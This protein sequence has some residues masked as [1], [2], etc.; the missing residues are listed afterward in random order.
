[1]LGVFVCKLLTLHGT[2]VRAR[3]GKTMK[4]K[5]VT[6]NVVKVQNTVYAFA[7]N[8]NLLVAIDI[9][10]EKISV[11][12]SI[13]NEDFLTQFLVGGIVFAQGKLY[14]IPHHAKEMWIVDTVSVNWS[15]YTLDAIT[16]I[17]NGKFNAAFLYHDCIYMVGFRYPGILVHD[18]INNTDTEYRIFTETDDI[19]SNDGYIRKNCCLR[20]EVLYAPCMNKNEI[21]YFNM[22]DKKW[23][24]FNV[25]ESKE[26]FSGIAFYNGH[27]V[28]P[29]RFGRNTIICDGDGQ[30]I[31]SFET[32]NIEDV[33]LGAY[34]FEEKVIVPGKMPTKSLIIDD[35]KV[36]LSDKTYLAVGNADNMVYTQNKEFVL[37]IYE[38]EKL[39]F[40]THTIVDV[41]RDLLQSVNIKDRILTEN[42]N[43]ID[44]GLFIELIE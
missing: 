12:G 10:T 44:L 17:G 28:L 24:L 34:L 14:L 27:F 43:G 36:S 33:F 25:G 6:D 3:K 30:V 1:M 2:N 8:V 11:L 7:Q 21:L 29:P 39:I 23:K 15:K 20:N 40:S 19:V 9:A 32:S 22:D 41:D 4:V 37:S 18:V 31:K 13:P 26:G 16:T 35:A 42:N 38:D 5:I